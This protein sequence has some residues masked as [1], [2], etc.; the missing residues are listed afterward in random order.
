[1]STYEQVAY[2]L[3]HGIESAEHELDVDEDNDGAHGKVEGIALYGR[4]GQVAETG[5]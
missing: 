1:M 5:T 3:L 2:P 4:R